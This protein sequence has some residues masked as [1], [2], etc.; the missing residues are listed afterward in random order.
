M[1]YAICLDIGT[2]NVQG[3][4]CD[5]R[6]T[7]QIGYLT[8]KNSQVFYGADVITRLGR[9]LKSAS[10]YENIR[11]GLINDLTILI[12]LLLKKNSLKAE[13]IDK[14]IACGNSAM[15]HIA[16]KLPLENL[17]YA[18]F[19][20]AYK[21]NT[22]KS[23]AE[24]IGIKDIPEHTPFYFLPNIGGFVGSDALCVIIH[25]GM[26]ESEA[27]ILSVDLG[28]N[29]EIMLGSKKKI[30]VASTSAGPAFESWRI[31]CGVYGSTLIDIMTDLLKKGVIDKSGYMGQGKYI[32]AD[33]NRE[34]KVTQKDVRGFQLA[35]AAISTGINLLRTFFRGEKIS[36]V[37]VTGI[38]GSKLNKFNAKEIGIFPEDIQSS[39]IEVKDKA[40]L[41]GAASIL[42]HKDIDAYLSRIIKITEHIELSRDPD[43]QGVFTQAMQF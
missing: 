12:A 39:K 15:H 17:A 9:S 33:G 25:T 8:I 3:L 16:L 7:R 20:P 29:G 36:K 24:K 27:L 42:R 14:I 11:Q 43:F 23:T 21:G 18:P 32:Y 6:G 5:M 40:A 38:F 2:T 41:L 10:I 22:Y 1:R 13:D 30:A 4:I 28:T 26:H 19:E 37:Y 34:I 35:K 31:K